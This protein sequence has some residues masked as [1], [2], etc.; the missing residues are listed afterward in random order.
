[1]ELLLEYGVNVHTPT[2]DG[3]TPLFI[4]SAGGHTEVAALLIEIGA[5]NEQGWMGLSPMDSARAMNQSGALKT[6]CAYESQFQGLIL[7]DRRVPCVVSWPGIYARLWDKVRIDRL[8]I[9]QLAASAA[10]VAI[11]D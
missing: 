6:L 11:K 8:H 5:K 1:V 3:L 2:A 9:Q 4:A 10:S 7:P